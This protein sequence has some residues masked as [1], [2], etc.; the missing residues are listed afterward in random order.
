M[1]CK[2][3]FYLDTKCWN[4]HPMS[5]EILIAIASVLKVPRYISGWCNFI[6][7]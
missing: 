5:R 3:Q 7:I 4:M 1:L 2:L 6:I